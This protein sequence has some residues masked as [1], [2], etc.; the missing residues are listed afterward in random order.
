MPL[1]QGKHG[2]CVAACRTQMAGQ[3]MKAAAGQRQ[4]VQQLYQG[5]M[6]K[7]EEQGT[8]RKPDAPDCRFALCHCR[9]G[10]PVLSRKLPRRMQ[11]RSMIVPMPQSPPVNS[12]RMPVPI[13]PT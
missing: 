1:K 6:Q 12:Q 4:T 9:S 3:F 13:F 10:V 8:Q 2:T 7:P 5:R 11:M